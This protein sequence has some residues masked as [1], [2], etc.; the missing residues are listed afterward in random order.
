MT[1]AVLDVGRGLA[2]PVS[3]VVCILSW[4]HAV[5]SRTNR[6]MLSYYSARRRTQTVG[7]GPYRSLVVCDDRL[8][9]TFLS[10]EALSKR[11]RGWITGDFV[12]WRG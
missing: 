11:A 4:R 1:G 12:T 8:Y 10:P 3:S 9:L 7:E 2:L 6:D 5:Q